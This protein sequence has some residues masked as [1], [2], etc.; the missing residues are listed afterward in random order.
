MGLFQ[1]LI[2]VS[3]PNTLPFLAKDPLVNNGTMSIVDVLRTESW[4]SQ[5]APVDANV[6]NSLNLDG[7]LDLTFRGTGGVSW[8]NGVVHAGNSTGEKG[9]YDFPSGV[10]LHDKSFTLLMWIKHSTAIGSSEAYAGRALSNANNNGQFLFSKQST[11][12]NLLWYA[13]N[14]AGTASNIRTSTLVNNTVYQIGL[15]AVISG[16]ETLLYTHLNGATSLSATFVGAGLAN[17]ATYRP[18][19][20]A[21]GNLN[22]YNSTKGTFYRSLLEN[23]TISG[24]T[25]AEV[26]LAD[27]TANNGRFV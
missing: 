20:F 23:L 5:I 6:L 14:A 26:A 24:R 1:E 10:T 19:L 27:Y 11:G 22:F 9:R 18:S 4:P 15:S 12:N 25:P 21:Y 7:S 16:A 2:G 3:F 13:W 8:S 17:Y